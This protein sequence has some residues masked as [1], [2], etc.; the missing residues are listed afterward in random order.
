MNKLKQLYNELGFVD[1]WIDSKERYVDM[2]YDGD[3]EVGLMD[4]SI[5]LA[6]DVED[7]LQEEYA[8]GFKSGWLMGKLESQ[9]SGYGRRYSGRK[10]KNRRRIWNQILRLENLNKRLRKF[11]YT[12]KF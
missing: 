9:M 10:P 7:T 6:R 1:G 8:E 2:D 3:Y 5:A 11:R 12:L 4:E